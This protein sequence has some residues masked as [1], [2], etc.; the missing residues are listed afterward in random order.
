MRF[1][2]LLVALFWDAMEHPAITWSAISFV[3]GLTFGLIL[4]G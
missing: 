1:L 3:V 4:R 2:G